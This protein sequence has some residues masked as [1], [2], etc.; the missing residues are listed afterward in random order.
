[1]PIGRIARLPV[2]GLEQPQHRRPFQHAVGTP[3]AGLIE[4]R[5]MGQHILARHGELGARRHGV[6][7]GAA[8]QLELVHGVEGLLDGGAAGEEAV[9]AHDQGIVRPEIVDDTLA[10]LEV[11]R[12][13]L[14]VVIAEVADEAD[15]GLRQRQQPAFHRRDRDAGTG[16][17]VQHAGYIRSRLVNGA[18]DHVA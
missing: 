14:V 7:L 2:L 17:R 15:R 9:V 8:G 5:G 1:M 4:V 12:R 13:P 6:D 10:L 3:R 11:D 18:M 16:M